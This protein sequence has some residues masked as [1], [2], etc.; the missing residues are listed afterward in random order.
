V[1]SIL[2]AGCLTFATAC[3]TAAAGTD[4]SIRLVEVNNSGRGSPGGLSDVSAILKESLGFNSCAFVASAWVRLPADRQ[5]RELGDY[6]VTCSGPSQNLTLVVTRGD[7]RLL[8]TSVTLQDNTPL[9]LGGFPAAGG[10]H[11]LVFLLR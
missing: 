1:R 4:L 9:I 3:L 7:R 5:Q 2:V 6:I 11:V 8:K 10:K